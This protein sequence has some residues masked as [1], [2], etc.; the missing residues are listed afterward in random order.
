MLP[1]YY[2]MFMSALKHENLEFSEPR[3][4]PEKCFDIAPKRFGSR[5]LRFS[6]F[7]FLIPY[8]FGCGLLRIFYAWFLSPVLRL[9]YNYNTYFNT[10]QHLL[11]FSFLP[12]L[13]NRMKQKKQVNKTKQEKEA[14]WGRKIAQAFNYQGL[15]WTK[16]KGL[17]TVCSFLSLFPGKEGR[18]CQKALSLF[19]MPEIIKNLWSKYNQFPQP[20]QHFFLKSFSGAFAWTK[21]PDKSNY[22]LNT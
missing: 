22:V 4:I 2:I 8:R 9:C 6:L 18:Q 13:E 15:L 21:L 14:P 10:S 17:S 5:F 12:G 7:L 16:G 20:C 3:A 1:I 19:S 11:L